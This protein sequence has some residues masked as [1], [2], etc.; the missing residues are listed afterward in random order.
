ML[1]PESHSN[2][3]QDLLFQLSTQSQSYVWI[4]VPTIVHEVSV[5]EPDE[6]FATVGTFVS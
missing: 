4:S 1:L 2:R 6:D 5:S 3:Y